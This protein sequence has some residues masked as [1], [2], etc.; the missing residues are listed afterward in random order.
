MTDI[1]RSLQSRRRQLL[2][3]GIALLALYVVLPQIGVFRTTTGHFKNLDWQFVA[4]AVGATGLTYVAAAGT[5]YLLAIKPIRYSST[6]LVQV[7]S[8][9]INRLLPAGIGGLGANY[10]YLHR[11]GHDRTQS[12]TVVTV[13]NTL[14]MVGHAGLL[15]VVLGLFSDRLNSFHAT[16]LSR[17][18]IGLL[19]VLALAAIGLFVFLKRPHERFKKLRQEVIRQLEH[20]RQRPGRL[21][22]A[23]LTSMSLTIFNVL[24]LWYCVHALHGSLS[25]VSVLLIFTLGIG[26]GTIVPSPGGLGG[27][28]AGLVAGFV[29]YGLSDPQALATALLYRLISYWLPLVLG[30]VAFVVALRLGLFRLSD[31]A[32]KPPV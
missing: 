31:S 13:N 9:F 25:F 15:L 20:Y 2:I 24:S 27:V 30:A 29:A 21:A 10:V 16:H 14:G 12:V 5:Y 22:G 32:P 19:I 11:S 28:E 3:L 26:V 17:D 23:L 7:A 18:L 4:A 1:W 8:N 6:L